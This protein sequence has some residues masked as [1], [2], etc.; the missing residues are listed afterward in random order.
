MGSSPIA[1][2]FEKGGNPLFARVSVFSCL[3]NKWTKMD[4]F[5]QNGQKYGQF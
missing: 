5:G 1:G 3:H 2:M 4:D